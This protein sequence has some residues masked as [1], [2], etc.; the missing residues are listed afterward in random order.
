MPMAIVLK[1]RDARYSIGDMA[2]NGAPDECVSR[3]NCDCQQTSSWIVFGLHPDESGNYARQEQEGGGEGGAGGEGGGGGSSGSGSGDDDGDGDGGEAEAPRCDKFEKLEQNGCL[4]PE[5]VGRHSKPT[6]QRIATRALLPCGIA[7][8]HPLMEEHIERGGT[9]NDAFKQSLTVR[10][11]VKRNAQFFAVSFVWPS[12]MICILACLTFLISDGMADLR[13]DMCTTLLLTLLAMKLSMSSD[14]P[15]TCTATYLDKKL[16]WSIVY[17]FGSTVAH[18]LLDTEWSLLDALLLTDDA[19]L[20]P[21][22][23]GGGEVAAASWGGATPHACAFLASLF[24]LAWLELYFLSGRCRGATSL[25]LG[26]G[27]RFYE[28]QNRLW[29]YVVGETAQGRRVVLSRAYKIKAAARGV[30]SK[31]KRRISTTPRKSL[32]QTGAGAGASTPVA[33]AAEAAATDR[34]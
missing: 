26:G 7:G 15:Q 33:V 5:L 9:H 11:K 1:L 10:F 25:C 28:A 34:A 13:T 22:G 18:I 31:V 23:G 30:Q 32:T 17:I 16:L 14:V 24:C 27:T 12:T 20:L 8:R 29:K 6:G 21:S 19:E 2:A 3:C 4:A